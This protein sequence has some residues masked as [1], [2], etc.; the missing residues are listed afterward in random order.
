MLSHPHIVSYRNSFR[1]D[2]LLH[3]VFD[4]V[5]GGMVKV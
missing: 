2:G 5:C 3:L 1:H 4:Y